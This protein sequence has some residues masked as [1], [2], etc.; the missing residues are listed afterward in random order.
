MKKREVRVAARKRASGYEVRWHKVADAEH[1]AITDGRERVAIDHAIEKLKV[2]GPA[3][4]APHQS[5]VKSNTGEG[6]RELRPRQG[7][8]RWRPIYRRFG[9]FF[10]ILAI[11]PETEIDPAGYDR[12]V[13]EAQKRRQSLEKAL[14]QAM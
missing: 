1:A 13:G 9:E 11:A 12:Q 7:R 10:V 5:G 14:A 8:S 2:D 3:L 4:R 6:L